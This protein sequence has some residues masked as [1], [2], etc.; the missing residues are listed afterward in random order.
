MVQ[1]KSRPEFPQF[2][3]VNP[4]K[5]MNIGLIW[6]SLGEPHCL[7]APTLPQ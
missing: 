1:W 4:C 7:F 6:I 2:D 5:P 3:R